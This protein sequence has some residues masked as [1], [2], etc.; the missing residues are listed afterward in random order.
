MTLMKWAI[1]RDA[2]TVQG[3]DAESYLHSQVSQDIDDM[4]D[5][6]SRLSFLLEPKGNIEGF[7]RVTKREEGHFLLDTNV[8]YGASLVSSLERFKLRTKADFHLHN[9]RMV[10]VLGEDVPSDLAP[11]VLSVTSPWL[12]ETYTDL[13]GEAIDVDLPPCAEEEYESLR[14]RCGLPT[15]GKELQVGGI[16]NESGLVHLAVSFDKGCYRGQ[17]LVE[18]ISARGGGRRIIRR[19]CSDIALTSGQDLFVSSECVGQVL[20]VTK[21]APFVGFALVSGA[22]T[23]ATTDGGGKISVV[24]L[25]KV[26]DLQNPSGPIGE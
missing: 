6:E 23:E 9:W 3:L 17:E 4:V 11:G 21:A 22:I 12:C 5:A 15:F 7:F 19:I 20:S 1:E 13:L 25:E 8:G 26:L 10:S 14:F 2:V 24:P 16:P 18:R